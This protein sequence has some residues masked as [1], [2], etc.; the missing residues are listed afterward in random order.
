MLY[1]AGTNLN[2]K[3]KALLKVALT[4][5]HGIGAKKALLLCDQLGLS[6]QIKVNQLTRT[7]IDQLVQLI[8]QNHLIDTELNKLVFNDIKRL[9]Q[10]G[11]YRGLRHN[12]GLPLRGQRTHSNAKIARKQNK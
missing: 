5:I 9:K 2:K 11:S 6:T 8:T 7:Q 4:L 3:N 10:I 1:I 12:T